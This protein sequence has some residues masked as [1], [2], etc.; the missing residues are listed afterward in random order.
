MKE[1]KSQCARDAQRT[2]YGGESYCDYL[3]ATALEYAAK[4]A[5]RGQTAEAERMLS[6]SLSEA[7]MGNNGA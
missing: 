2:G 4:F 1:Y 3:E 7:L 5:Q 6:R